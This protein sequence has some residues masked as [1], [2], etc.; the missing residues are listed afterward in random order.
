MGSFQKIL[1]PTKYRAIDTS[2]SEQLISE[3]LVT[4]S[5]FSGT[6]DLSG[7]T[8]S[9]DSP[10]TN[11]SGNMQ[12]NSDGSSFSRAKQELTT[13]IGATYKVSANVVVNGSSN[14][15]LIGTSE[16]LGDLLTYRTTGTGEIAQ[17]FVATGTTSYL[18]IRDGASSS[19]STYSYVSVHRV[20]S[21]G[22]NNHGQIYSGRALEFDGV[23]DYLDMGSNIINGTTWTVAFWIGNYTEGSNFDFIIGSG[24]ADNIALQSAV[25]GEGDHIAYRCQTTNGSS[26]GRYW[27][28]GSNIPLQ[29]GTCRLVITT[30]GTTIKSYLNGQEHGTA[31]VGVTQSTVSDGVLPNTNAQIRYINGGYSASNYFVSCFMSD[32]QIW[33]T[34]WSASDAL[35][36]Y[37]NPE[38]LVLNNSGTSLTESN[39]KVWYPMQDGHRGQ[40]SYVMDGANT[41]LGDEVLG[42]PEFNTDVAVN[43]A[44]TYWTTGTVSDSGWSISGGKA[45]QDGSTD[46]GADNFFKTSSTVFVTGVTYKI[47]LDV[48]STTA[49]ALFDVNDINGT[50]YSNVEAG[51]TTFYFTAGGNR[52]IGIDAGSGKVFDINSISIKPVNDKHH[53][54]TVFMGDNLYTAANALKV[55]ANGTTADETDAT[56]GWSSNGT[57]TFTTSSTSHSGS[58][59]IVYEANVNHGGISTDLQPY[60]TVGRTYKLSLFVRHTTGGTAASDQSLRFSDASNLQSNVTEIAQVE[61]SDIT[62][63][64]VSKEFIYDDD[65]YRYF[66]AKELNGDG[67]SGD[68]GLFMDT[69]Y[70]KEVGTASG[71]TDAD[72]Q[73][74]I[75][76]TALQSYNQLAWFG[77]GNS[78]AGQTVITFADDDALDIGT[79]DLTV[80]CWVFKNET[81][82]SATQPIFRKGG[83]NGLGYSIAVNSSEKVAINLSGAGSNNIWGYTANDAPLGE[84]FHVVGLWDRSGDM[85]IYINGEIQ[86][87]TNDDITA[88][89]ATNMN[90]SSEFLIGNTGDSGSASN[91]FEGCVTELS[92]WPG[93]LFTQA[94][95]NEMYNDGK[96][97]DARDHSRGIASLK[98]YWKNN[99]LA[100]WKDLSGEGNHSHANS[101]FS[102]ETLLLPAGIDASRDTQGFLMNRQ[103]DTNSLNLPDVGDV[104]ADNTDNVYVN[105]NSNPLV[106]ST[107]GADHNP[108]SISCWIK[109]RRTYSAGPHA[110]VWLGDSGTSFASIAIENG[111]TAGKSN[112]CLAVD[113]DN[114]T[115]P[116]YYD[117][118]TDDAWN[119]I[120]IC[121]ESGTHT[122]S[123]DQHGDTGEPMVDSAAT[124]AVDELI[125]ALIENNSDSSYGKITDNTATNIISKGFDPVNGTLETGTMGLSKSGGTDGEWDTNDTYNVIKVYV[126]GTAVVP[127]VGDDSGSPS[128]V[129]NNGKYYIGKDDAANRQFVGKVDD[130]LIYDDKWL[131]EKEVDRIYN[132][133][134]RSHK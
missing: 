106:T 57:S 94:E 91:Q 116:T 112:I 5:S 102:G 7:W 113:M 69:M 89:T 77:T 127:N 131:T 86:S 101:I 88:L 133:G 74:D 125:N 8:L 49:G 73:L 119:H 96:V 11:A 4:N 118:I 132:A 48:T 15:I 33:D 65:E 14:D 60:L 72:Q 40:Q 108:F 44:G 115:R 24:T 12:M 36:D 31:T 6:S 66:G 23:S 41:G 114:P 124:W 53:A 47:T 51:T 104:A 25:S 32:C 43:T 97:L 71:W 29:N 52:A 30:D 34:A 54:T 85:S 76:Q 121:C 80:S 128:S 87:L 120:V 10:P 27:S 83:W 117:A 98:G 109:P 28:L 16:N 110:A 21:F 81:D 35:Y 58:K 93:L 1:K 105:L 63:T 70:I 22:N 61:P 79:N 75:A 18:Q 68:G 99:G 19:G 126:N 59:S 42:D 100:Q 37:L 64:E 111:E 26:T 82:Q 130:V 78:T 92:F 107:I 90:N 38:S 122:G 9:S 2:T 45:I 84:W 103:K 129:D 123:N 46:G 13:V 56:T 67:S 55:A 17:Y 20:E 3:D 134:K 39:L 50:V 95:V 62:F